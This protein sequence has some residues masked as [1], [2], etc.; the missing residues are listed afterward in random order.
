MPTRMRAFRHGKRFSRR[1]PPC[2]V[3]D[4][5]PYHFTMPLRVPPAQRRR[6]LDKNY[7]NLNSTTQRTSCGRLRAWLY[8]DIV[9]VLQAQLDGN[10]Q[11]RPSMTHGVLREDPAQEL[12]RRKIVIVAERFRVHWMALETHSRLGATYRQF[13]LSPPQHSVV[14]CCLRSQAPNL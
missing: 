13:P 7:Q 12:T 3:D 8:V 14:L 9:P 4:R 10:L 6:R 11:P 1:S 2:G 5:P